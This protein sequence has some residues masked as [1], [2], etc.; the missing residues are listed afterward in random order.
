MHGP[1][2]LTGVNYN[3]LE[4]YEARMTH[5]PQQFRKLDIRKLRRAVFSVGE[6]YGEHALRS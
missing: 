1:S 5:K 3:T 4:N 2:R 6:L